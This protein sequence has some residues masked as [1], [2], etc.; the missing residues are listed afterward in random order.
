LPGI[1]RKGATFDL[2][3]GVHRSYAQ[4][5]ATALEVLSDVMEAA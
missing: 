4:D 3:Q 1:R 2:H 5:C